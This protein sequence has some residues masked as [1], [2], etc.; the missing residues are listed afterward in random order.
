MSGLNNQSPLVSICMPVYNGEKYI[1]EAIQSVTSQSYS[2]WELI[3]VNDGS[4]DNTASVLNSISDSR[5]KVFHQENK[6]QCSA[7]NFAFK[8]SSG[9]FIKFFD[10]DD[11][12]SSDMIQKQ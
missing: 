12:L 6:G 11:L 7:A 4:K 8:N 5:I 10:A 1:K 3:I 2:N 9:S